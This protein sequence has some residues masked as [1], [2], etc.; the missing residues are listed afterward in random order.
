MPAASAGSTLPSGAASAPPSAKPSAAAQ[1]VDVTLALGYIPNV[2]F[3]PFYVAQSKGFYKDEGI[4]ISFDNGTSPD[5]IKS[6]GAGKFKFAIADSDTVISA[7]A[8]NIPVTYVAGFYVQSP[9]AIISLNKT[10]ITAPA[11]LKG[12]KIGLPGRYGSSYIGL[13][14]VLNKAG[15]TEK[16]VDVQEIGYNQ[17][18]QLLAGKVDAVV[19]FANNDALQ[20]AAQAGGQPNVLK[21]GDVIPFVGNGMV[22]NGDELKNETKLVQGMSRAMLRGVQYTAQH[23]DEAFDITV[24]AVPEAGGKDAAVNKQVLTA[25]I[26]LF[27]DK[28]TAANGL[29]WTDP[30]SWKSMEDTMTKAGLIKSTPPIDQVMTN[31]FASKDIAI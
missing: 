30:A 26:P 18:P 2:Q 31:Q 27:S 9:A 12:K 23:P 25:T 1:A 10:G 28:S 19:G 6:V 5:L 3:A 17:A 24:K 14:G 16:D 11:Q 15:L 7:R 13:L 20:V 22:T 29:G 4:N 8:E 21:I